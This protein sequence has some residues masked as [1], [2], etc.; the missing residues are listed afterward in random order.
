MFLPTKDSFYQE[1][2]FVSLQIVGVCQGRFVDPADDPR[3]KRTSNE[4]GRTVG[5]KPGLTP[6]SRADTLHATS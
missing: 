4:P 6:T 2:S 3:V 5:D 1:I